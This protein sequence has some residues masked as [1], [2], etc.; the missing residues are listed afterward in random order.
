MDVKIVSD[1]VV[2]RRKPFLG[3]NHLRSVPPIAKFIAVSSNLHAVE[4]AYQIWSESDQKWLRYC[5]SKMAF[6]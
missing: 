1:I 3:S 6:G 4:E 5:Q 2:S